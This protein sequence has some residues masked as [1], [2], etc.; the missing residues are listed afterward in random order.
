MNQ[1]I[2]RAAAALLLSTSLTATA[3]A[4]LPSARDVAG[5]YLGG[6]AAAEFALLDETALEASHGKMLP[7]LPTVAAITGVDLA[8]S[9]FFWGVYVPYITAG[10]SHQCSA[11]GED[12]SD[13][14]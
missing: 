12:A 14:H 1:T 4:P 5:D 8:L 7:L 10:N 6:V 3:A 9:A 11:C 13:Q 2:V